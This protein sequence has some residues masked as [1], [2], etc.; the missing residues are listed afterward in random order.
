[1]QSATNGLNIAASSRADYAGAGDGSL[2]ESA[3][4]LQRWFN[5]AS[6]S[7]PAPLH[8]GNVGRN[9]LAGPGTKQLDFSVFK[10]FVLKEG[11]A[12]SLQFRAE[13]FNLTNTP[14]FNNPVSTIGA[15]GAGAIISAGSPNTFQRVSREVQVAL[16]LYF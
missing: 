14:Q 5:T 16:K 8:F 6:F 9:T 15:P 1:V 7:A 3:R 4:T 13:A 10:N 2:P 11:S 12:R